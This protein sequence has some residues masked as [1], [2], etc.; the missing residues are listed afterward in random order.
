MKT[1]A[2]LRISTNKQ[3]LSNQRLSILDYAYKNKIEIN[4]FI[5]IQISA[6]K[7]TRER[8]IENL[9]IELK[10]NDTLIVTELSRLGR[11]L[12]QIIRIVDELIKRHIKLISIKEN[13][14]LNDKGN[15]QTKVM[16]A[17]FSIFAEVEHDLISQ[18]TKLGMATAKAKGKKIGRPKGALGKSKLDG[19]EEDIKNF[20]SKKVSKA[21]I[22]R[23]M[24]VSYTGICSFIKNRNLKEIAEKEFVKK[25]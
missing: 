24:G 20:L 22:A 14:I 13:I 3:D 11:S 15:L 5:E 6:K 7:N 23:I 10:E 25:P 9:L 21:S 1:I 18:R 2:Y 16:I 4:S 8:K 12:G 19:K 17:L